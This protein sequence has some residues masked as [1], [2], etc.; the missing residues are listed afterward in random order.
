M[1]DVEKAL[2]YHDEIKELTMTIKHLVE[3]CVDKNENKDKV[4]KMYSNNQTSLKTVRLMKSNND[5]TRL[6]RTKTFELRFFILLNHLR[7]LR[8]IIDDEAHDSF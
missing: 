1:R 4:Y 2:I 5:Q 8:N 7:K 6:R 3:K